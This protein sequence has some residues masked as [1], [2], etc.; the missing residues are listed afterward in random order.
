MYSFCSPK[1]YAT[2]HLHAMY[3]FYP[4]TINSVRIL[5]VILQ[6]HL[7]NY[8]KALWFW[9]GFFCI[10]NKYSHSISKVHTFLVHFPFSPL[11]GRTTYTSSLLADT[12]AD[13]QKDLHSQ[14]A[15]FS[16]YDIFSQ[17]TFKKGV[18]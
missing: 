6:S 4:A 18:Q 9:F 3:K 13:V 12:V 11:Y 2:Q 10:Q 17:V 1:S 8:V 16:T 14:H 15:P 5:H 7:K